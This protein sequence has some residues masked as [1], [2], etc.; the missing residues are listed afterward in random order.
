MIME[1][2]LNRRYDGVAKFCIAESIESSFVISAYLLPVV[3]AL[4][5][6]LYTC[7]L[8]FSCLSHSPD[9]CPSSI[10]SSVWCLFIFPK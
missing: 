4:I 9:T 1:G 5:D 8:I 2:R 6:L 10:F 7:M 3:A